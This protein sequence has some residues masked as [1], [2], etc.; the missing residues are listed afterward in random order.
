M[1]LL[2]LH[3]ESTADPSTVAWYVG[4][5]RPSPTEPPPLSALR[6]A[7]V[8]DSFVVEPEHVRT[9]LAP[10]RT[11]AEESARVRDAVRAGL[12]AA[13]P[14][15]DERDRLL[16]AAAREVVGEIV[17]PFARSHGGRITLAAVGDGRVTVHLEGACHGCPAAA[18]TVRA[19]LERE[20]RAR[21]P[22]LVGVDE[23]RGPVPRS[24]PPRA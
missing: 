5:T 15:P 20:L 24:V 3:P 22:W 2:P 8:L 18:V 17:D 4:P 7:G 21:C 13:P 10:G 6:E 16:L 23:A 14:G 9:T 12:A 19:R 11:W 1:T